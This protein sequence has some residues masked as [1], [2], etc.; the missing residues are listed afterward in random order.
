MSAMT[1]CPPILC[2]LL[3][4]VGLVAGCAPSVRPAAAP[5]QPK[6]I[7]SRGGGG[8]KEGQ[9]NEPII[10]VNPKDPTRLVM[11]YSG[12]KLG[13]HGGSIGKAWATAADPFTW[14]EDEGNP[15]LLNKTP[16][17]TRDVGVRL[18]SVIYEAGSDEYWIY[19]TTYG[20]ADS[21]SLAMCPA[22]ADG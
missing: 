6:M 4:V 20:A 19:Y 1:E 17:P 8:W 12:M 14:H 2:K 16:S 11:F 3:V 22:G 5:S 21:I 10:L 9:V 13:G 15:I 7:I 18:D